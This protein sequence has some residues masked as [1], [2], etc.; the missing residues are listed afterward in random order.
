MQSGTKVSVHYRRS[1]RLSGVVV[2]RDSTVLCKDRKNI[3]KMNKE[4]RMLLPKKELI[5]AE[6]GKLI[7]IVRIS[8]YLLTTTPTSHTYTL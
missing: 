8:I 3:F 4:V 6:L 7:I 2:K 1:G 5:Q